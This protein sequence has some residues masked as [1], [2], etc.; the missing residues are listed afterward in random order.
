MKYFAIVKGNKDEYPAGEELASLEEAEGFYN[1]FIEGN[2][3]GR[4]WIFPTGPMV[5]R[6][7]PIT[8]YVL[9]ERPNE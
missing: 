3:D 6:K 2:S 1:D 5:A 8:R 4:V 7:A 9:E